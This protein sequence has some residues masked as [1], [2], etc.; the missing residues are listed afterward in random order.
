MNTTKSTWTLRCTNT[1]C[2][3]TYSRDTGEP[4]VICTRCGGFVSV[5]E[6]ITFVDVN[7]IQIEGNNDIRSN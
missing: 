5:T 7:Y 6:H 4:D 2:G 3:H 1:K